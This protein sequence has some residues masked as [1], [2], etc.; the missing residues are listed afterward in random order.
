[1]DF[2]A[3]M[4]VSEL[5]HSDELLMGLLVD[6]A[7]AFQIILASALWAENSQNYSKNLPPTELILSFN[8]YL[9]GNR[10]P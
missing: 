10:R 3:P 5:Y 6:T 9:D 4:I 2:G 1:M 8:N 7:I